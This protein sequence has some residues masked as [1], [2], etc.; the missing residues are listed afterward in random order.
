VEKRENEAKTAARLLKRWKSQSPFDQ[1]EW[2]AR[3]LS[4]LEISENDLVSLSTASFETDLP[5]TRPEWVDWAGLIEEC[6]FG[7]YGE[8]ESA[9]ERELQGFSV[10]A[11]PL[12]QRH[13]LRV[14]AAIDDLVSVHPKVPFDR[15][16]VM[17]LLFSGLP[18]LLGTLAG[19]V[20]VLELHV[21]KVQ[22]A[23]DGATPEERFRS[24]T[25]R[26]RRPE[27]ALELLREYPILA[28]VLFNAIELWAESGLEFVSRLCADWSDI[29]SAFSGGSDPGLLEEI[30]MGAGDRHRRGRSVLLARFSSGFRLVYKPKSLQMDMRFGQLLEWLRDRGA[31]SLRVPK[32]LDRGAYGWTEFVTPDPCRDRDEVKRF[33]EKQGALLALLYG[34]EANDCHSENIIAAG[35]DPVLIDLESLFHPDYGQGDPAVYRSAA[36]FVM[37]NSVLR[38]GLLPHPQQGKDDRLVDRSGLGGQGGQPALR[39]T[40]VWERVGTDDMHLVRKLYGLSAAAN[41]PTLGGEEVDL[42]EFSEEIVK[43][44]RDM[45]EVLVKNNAELLGQGSIL[46]QFAGIEV[47]AIFRLTQFYATIL[48]ESFH[49]DLLRDALERDRLFSRLWFGLDQS[50]LAEKALRLIPYELDDLWRGDIP[51]FSTRV[52]SRD[53]YASDG[54]CIPELLRRSGWEAVRSRL[55]R[56]APE[57]L[58][59]QI[60]FIKGSLTAVAIA[61]EPQWTTYTVSRSTNTG[62]PWDLIEYSRLIGDRLLELAVWG[63]QGVSWVGLSL[64]S[65]RHWALLP[66][67]LDLYGGLPGIVL[68]LAYLG[69]VTGDSTYSRVAETA[70]SSIR[71][72]LERKESILSKSIGGFEGW[73]GL[74]HVWVHL[75]ALWGRNDLL[76]EAMQM[77][78]AMEPLIAMDRSLD[79]VSGSAGGIAVLLELYRNVKE[80]KILRLAR[81]MGDK[82]VSQAVP[83]GKGVG[84]LVPTNPGLPLTGFSHGASGFAWSLL[85]L[86]HATGVTAYKDISLKA[87]AF[88]RGVFMPETG[89][90]PDLREVPSIDA[91]SRKFMTAWCHGAPGIGLSRLKMLSLLRDDKIEEDALAAFSSTL[92][93]GFGSNHSLCHG[94][95][96]NLDFL[97]LGSLVLG[98]PAWREHLERLTAQVV[99]SIDEFGWLCGVPLGTETPGL[100]CGLAGIGYQLLRLARPEHVPS[101]LTLDSPTILTAPPPAPSAP[102]SATPSPEPARSSTAGRLA[103][104]R[105]GAGRPRGCHGRRRCTR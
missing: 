86:Y 43:G 75:A 21:A 97:L 93:G 16:T 83:I 35:G 95:L 52:D 38:V 14:A 51:F 50:P 23:L 76:R 60:W 19:K 46:E 33:Y 48:S 29:C 44:F 42:V 100:L 91:G 87:L 82:I 78:E 6:F 12:V 68:F 30:D 96:G 81:S 24:F 85:N 40:P 73:G 65:G 84:W 4:E 31:P 2:F 71:A 9:L 61:S 11:L 49:P 64:I 8:S 22:G 3:L 105:R 17:R 62:G 13:Y 92:R 72:E 26:I 77:A 15:E 7:D 5:P 79:V 55:S 103:S 25:G 63:E 39:E 54:R 59:Q 56:L 90:W 36:S 27:I 66:F 104:G 101:V 20:G 80:A 99:M 94:D 102:Q 58:D 28:R 57:D 88:E 34:L 53:V 37:S 18:R 67:G 1:E 89:N 74:V 41:R 45:Y 69:W 47:R 10:I 32:V 70:L 98:D